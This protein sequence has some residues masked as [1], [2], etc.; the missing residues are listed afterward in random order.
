MQ[1][2]SVNAYQRNN[3]CRIIRDHGI[4]SHLLHI[5]PNCSEVCKFRFGKL[6]VIKYRIEVVD[7]VHAEVWR[8][9]ESVVSMATRQRITW[10]P[11]QDLFANTRNKN[12][13]SCTAIENEIAEAAVDR[14]TGSPA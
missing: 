2:G 11:N 5:A 6:N 3:I 13:A 12:V 8:K 7:R 9:H 1:A 4:R 14:G 10:T